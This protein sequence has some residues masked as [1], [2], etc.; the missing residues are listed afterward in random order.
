MLLSQLQDCSIAVKVLWCFFLL[1]LTLALPLHPFNPWINSEQSESSSGVLNTGNISYLFCTLVL[2]DN[3]TDIGVCKPACRWVSTLHS[4]QASSSSER[5]RRYPLDTVWPLLISKSPGEKILE[6][7]V[8]LFFLI[9][10]QPTKEFKTHTHKKKKKIKHLQN[11]IPKKSVCKQINKPS[12]VEGACISKQCNR[13]LLPFELF[14]V[15]S[16][17]AQY[18]N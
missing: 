1:P 15:S 4:A 11:L 16:Q 10:M 9:S 17:H 18:D 8:S 5:I 13:H 2:F 12:R 3:I 7:L 6:I 14:S